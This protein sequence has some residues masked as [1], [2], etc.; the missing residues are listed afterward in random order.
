MQQLPKPLRAFLSKMR[1]V[2]IEKN[3]GPVYT[4]FKTLD[5]NSK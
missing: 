2:T 5:F 3:L 4:G 1:L